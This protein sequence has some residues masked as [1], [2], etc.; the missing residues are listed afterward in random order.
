MRNKL[1]LAALTALVKNRSGMWKKA[2]SCPAVVIQEGGYPDFLLS[3]WFIT[4]LLVCK[5]GA[6]RQA[7]GRAY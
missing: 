4:L 1:W 7:F 5:N 6:D 2:E 3:T